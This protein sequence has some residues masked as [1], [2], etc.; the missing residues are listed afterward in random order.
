MNEILCVY[1]LAE[2]ERANSVANELPSKHP[3]E[4]IAR[5]CTSKIPFGTL[6]VDPKD[7]AGRNAAHPRNPADG[8]RS[9]KTLNSRDVRKEDH[10]SQT[11]GNAINRQLVGEHAVL[12]QGAGASFTNPN[13]TELGHCQ[14]DIECSRRFR[15]YLALFGSAVGSPRSLYL[16]GYRGRQRE[17]VSPR[18]I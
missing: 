6:I 10:Q 12:E 14:G 17:E 13:V 1:M 8:C 4:H 16:H 15:E 3:N 5:L 9:D 2:E 7:R 11:K 18:R